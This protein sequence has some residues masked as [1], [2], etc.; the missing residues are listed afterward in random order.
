MK[1]L[2]NQAFLNCMR[3]YLYI[4]SPFWAFHFQELVA[5]CFIHV[6]HW[7]LWCFLILRYLV[8]A[9]LNKVDAKAVVTLLNS[10]GSSL[11]S[12]HQCS[13][14]IIDCRSSSSFFSKSHILFFFFFLMWASLIFTTSFVKEIIARTFS[15]IKD[16][17]LIIA[18]FCICILLHLFCI[19]YWLILE[20]FLTLDFE[21]FNLF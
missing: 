18:L 2:L 10:H 4:G 8:K 20:M 14:L 9:Q 1:N 16:L 13:T 19:N 3:T 17:L 6:A 21:F 5:N 15:S 12:Y 7:C 11:A